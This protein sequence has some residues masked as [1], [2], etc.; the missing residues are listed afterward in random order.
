MP[1]FGIKAEKSPNIEVKTWNFFF[2]KSCLGSH[3]DILSLIL[4]DFEQQW[5]VQAW[6]TEKSINVQATHMACLWT[7]KFC[8]KM[9]HNTFF[10]TFEVVKQVLCIVSCTECP[11]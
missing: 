7:G 8:L 1:E 6:K 11:L 2:Y 10:S 9:H 3:G 4:F 5:A